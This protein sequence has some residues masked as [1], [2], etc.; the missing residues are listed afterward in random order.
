[1]TY[2]QRDCEL[3]VIESVY[4]DFDVDVSRGLGRELVCDLV[5]GVLCSVDEL[6]VVLDRENLPFSVVQPFRSASSRY[7]AF[8]VDSL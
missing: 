8:V 7:A 1:M 6:G 3:A 2:T 4:L 5:D